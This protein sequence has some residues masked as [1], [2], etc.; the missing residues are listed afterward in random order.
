MK[1]LLILALMGVHPSTHSFDQEMKS[2]GYTRFHNI[3]GH[4]RCYI[5]VGDTSYIRCADGFTTSS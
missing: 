5:Q 2:E 1:Y 3:D 4:K